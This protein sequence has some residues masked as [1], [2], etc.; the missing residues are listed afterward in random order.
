MYWWV[1]DRTVIFDDSTSKA[2]LAQSAEHQTLNLVVVGSSPTLGDSFFSSFAT[3]GQV[4]GAVNRTVDTLW[5]CG[6]GVRQSQ[7]TEHQET[8]VCSTMRAR[9]LQCQAELVT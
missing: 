6:W 4:L 5:A 1:R 3:I 7:I 8:C 2:R 9:L